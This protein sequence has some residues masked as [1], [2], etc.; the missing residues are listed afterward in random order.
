[1]GGISLALEHLKL[2]RLNRVG[3]KEVMPMSD[4]SKIMGL[5]VDDSRLCA[6]AVL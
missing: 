2:L 4:S 1:M 5:L 3:K 6:G